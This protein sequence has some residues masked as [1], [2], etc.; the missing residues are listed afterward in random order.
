MMQ[1]DNVNEQQST[2][3]VSA[4]AQPAAKSPLSLQTMMGKL[5]RGMS[6]YGLELALSVVGL[7]VTV[8]VINY[9]IYALINYMK[10]IEN[11]LAV[12]FVG[13]FS[14]WVAASMIIWLPL[15]VVF[16]LRT[17][18]EI[19][20][21]PATKERLIHKLFVGFF[22]FNVVLAIAGTLFSVVYALI[23]II[24]GIDDQAG[25]TAV[26]T[27]LPGVL[28]ALVNVGLFWAYGRHQ[29]LS[30]KT[31]SLLLTGFGVAVTIGLLAMS[32]SNVQGS[33]HDEKAAAD[34]SDIQTEITS[35]Y[36]DKRS[37]P[38][39]LSALDG[40]KT[41][42]KKRLAHYDYKKQGSSRYQLCATFKTDTQK[43]YGYSTSR[44]SYTNDDYST[45]AS[46][47]THGIGEKCFKLSAGYSSLYNDYLNKPSYNTQTDDSSLY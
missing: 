45:Y 2:A 24:V 10:G 23:R 39:D 43:A 34:L 21:H 17:R 5:S 46:F 27:I 19:E 30:R 31:F 37:L 29:G 8:G 26:R 47:T 18:A 1:P 42:T 7:L 9:A 14:L 40:L 13:E 22:L 38:S 12:R 44:S 3:A 32:V 36:G 16:Y 41:E 25:D 15:A 11:P 33:A 4:A 35:Y 6:W 28:A 20:R